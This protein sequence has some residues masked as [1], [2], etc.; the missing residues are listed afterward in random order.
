MAEKISKV[1]PF[2]QVFRI[3]DLPNRRFT[4]TLQVRNMSTSDFDFAVQITA[5]MGWGLGRSDFEFMR[6][7]EPDGSFVL[8]EGSTRMGIATTVSFGKIAWFGNLIVIQNARG[9][10]GGSL[11]V[12]RALEYL[13]SKKISTVGLYAYTEKI[14][15]YER[16]GFKADLDFIVMKGKAFASPSQSNVKRAE[17]KDF[18]GIIDFDES[19]FGESRSKMLEPIMSDPD[20]VAYVSLENK[21]IVGYSVAKV[22]RGMAELGPIA[23]AKGRIKTALSLIAA[24]LNDVKGNEVSIFVPEN[25]VEILTM[26]N[27]N[28]FSQA[29][30]VKR[31]FHGPPMAKDCIITPESLER[32]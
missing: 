4:I 19:C 31:M 23:C 6:E 25:E 2:V 3:T 1:Y 27:K 29:F 26:L 8:I 28:G 24:T 5:Q 9:K 15:F 21:R 14:S 17:K 30:R 16:L 32:G 22:F 18:H 11:L 10:G 20:N 13:R 12:N 7:L